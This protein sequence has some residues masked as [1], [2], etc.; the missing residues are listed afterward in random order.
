MSR[1][2]LSHAP[3]WGHVCLIRLMEM[4]SDAPWVGHPEEP[5]L[6]WESPHRHLVMMTP[7]HG[8]EA[9]CQGKGELLC[10]TIQTKLCQTSSKTL[11]CSAE[12]KRSPQCHNT[13]S[14]AYPVPD[15]QTSSWEPINEDMEKTSCKSPSPA[16]SLRHLK[17][18]PKTLCSSV[19][20]G[21]LFNKLVSSSIFKDE[22]GT[23][24]LPGQGSPWAN[25]TLQ[26]DAEGEGG[27][28]KSPPAPPPSPPP[29][30]IMRAQTLH[31]QA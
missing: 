19:F 25:A 18:C 14:G 13:G 30:S 31:P 21:H 24:E 3:T 23:C 26:R 5:N 8:L 17:C 20:A 10:Y 28:P 1:Q 15:T 22:W 4:S 7:H 27:C 2:W 12:N 6:S 29:F 9:G 16:Q 11:W